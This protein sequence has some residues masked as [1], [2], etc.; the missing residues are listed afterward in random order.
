VTQRSRDPSQQP[1]AGREPAWRALATGWLLARAL[2]VSGTAPL[3]PGPRAELPLSPGGRMPP[4]ALRSWPGIG[5]TR[6]LEIARAR[7][8]HPDDGPPLYLSQVPGIGPTTERAVDAWLG[9]GGAGP[10]GGG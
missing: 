4:R 1:P 2:L 6:A 3:E 10:C 8:R 9:P 7:W 5:E